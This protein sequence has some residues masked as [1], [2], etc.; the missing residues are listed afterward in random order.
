[1]NTAATASTARQVLNTLS[2][3]DDPRWLVADVVYCT[4]FQATGNGSFNT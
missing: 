4:R 1:M 3:M 2:L